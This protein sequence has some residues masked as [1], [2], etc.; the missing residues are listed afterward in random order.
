LVNERLKL[1]VVVTSTQTLY[2]KEDVFQIEAYLRGVD[3]VINL[4]TSEDKEKEMQKQIFQSSKLA[5]LGVL[6]AGIGHEINNPLSIIYGYLELM[7]QKQEY[8]ELIEPIEIVLQAADRIKNI[9]NGLKTY[10]RSDSHDMEDVDL[11]KVVNDVLNLLKIVYKHED[12]II[13]NGCK[14]GASLVRGNFGKVHQ[15]IMNLFSNARDALA[16]KGGII[17]IETENK[18][19][20]ILLKFSDNGI[21]IKK[22]DQN[23]I[24]DTFFTT[25]EV[26][27]GTGLGLGIV[28]S[29][30][31]SM[32]GNI[33][34]DSEY[35][36]GTSFTITL[37]VIDMAELGMVKTEK[38]VVKKLQGRALVVE[39]EDFIRSIICHYLKDFGLEVDEA[40]DGKTALEIIMKHE[41]DFIITDLKMSNMSGEGLIQEVRKLGR[42]DKIIVV[43]GG[44]LIDYTKQQRDALRELSDGL[45]M[46]PFKK[47][48]LYAALINGFGR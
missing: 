41:F 27:Q 17:R 20:N 22:E 48:D 40:S 43:T 45:L 30:L 35:G 28:Y 10:G 13:E 5:S 25:K 39:D 9:V 11:H 8:S 44:I 26:G 38:T 15:V 6:A 12:I 1:I 18:D 46:K 3:H 47:D 34:V 16:G 23:R 14:A 7:M 31:K 33:E 21:G 42:K 29:I 19:D 36:M 2:T 32:N 4:K 24:F 37:P